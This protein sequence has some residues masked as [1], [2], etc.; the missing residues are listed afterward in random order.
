MEKKDDG[1]L[2]REGDELRDLL[3]FLKG[4]ERDIDGLLDLLTAGGVGRAVCGDSEMMF[5]EG[6]ST[7]DNALI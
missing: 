5:I 1:E 7:E 2:G 3:D 6:V 4:M